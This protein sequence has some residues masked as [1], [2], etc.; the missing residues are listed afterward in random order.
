MRELPSGTVTFLFTD[1]EGS[2][3]LLH[4]LG[5]SGY[6]ESLDSHRRALRDA[7]AAHGGVEVDTQGDAFFVAFPDAEEALQA[8]REAQ[9]AL[10]A[11]S[12][13][14]RIGLHTGEPLLTDEGYVG[15]D[16]HKAARICSAGHGGQILVSERTKLVVEDG[17]LRPLGTHRLKDL[18]APEPLYQVGEAQFPPLKSLN[19]SNLPVQP[20][21]FVGREKELGEVL[22]LLRL[23]NGRV[24]TLTGPGGSGKTRLAVQA[25]AEVVEEQEHGVWWVGLQAVQDA[26]LVLP[27]IGSTV[28]AKGDL[29]EHIGNRR[30]LLVLDNLEQVVEVAPALGALLSS[31]PKLTLLVT[32]REPLHLAAEQEYPVPPFVE[33]EAV[34]FFFSRA[35][36]VRPEFEDD[37]SVRTI[38]RRLDYLPLALE[39]AAARVKA[40]SP[41]QILE[42]LEQRLPLLTGGSRDAPERQRTLRATIEWSH[43]LLSVEEQ[44]RF[45]RLSV[46]AGGC[47]LA[48]AED[49]AGA[50]VDSLQALVDKSLLRFDEERYTM[51]ETIR[52]YA[53]ERL[54]E[55]GEAGDVQRSHAAFFLALAESANMSAEGDYGRRYDILPPDQDNLRAAIDWLAAAG[56]VELA[57]RFAIA[58]ENFWVI[59]DPFEGMRR[60][61]ALLAEGGAPD[62]VRA[63]ALRCYAGSSFLAGK[64][65]QAQRANEE[66]LA[67]FREAN[68][69]RGIAE[70]LHRIGI[71]TLILGERERAQELLE[72]SL[73]LFRRLGSVRGEAEAI[74]ALGYVA[75]DAREFERALELFG[76]SEEMS[77][78]IGFTWW[79]QSMVAYGAD[80][81]FELGRIDASEQKGRR[82]LGL[83]RQVGDR[84]AMVYSLADLARNA[85]V[86]EDV[87]RAGRL[88]GALEA[89]A[90]RAPVGQWEA[91]REK[92]A[93]RVLASGGP[94]LESAREEGRRLSF[95]AAISEALENADA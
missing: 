10:A 47:T 19:Q 18:T 44:Q 76:R 30:M 68:D 41:A 46:F 42:R 27:A 73:A 9:Q 80:C 50:G 93:E 72:E 78:E 74:G 49:V 53:R 62:M 26:E 15:V 82:A 59:V 4:E 29:A 28:G 34:G 55:S 51:L 6:A 91:E 21:P 52:E 38:C 33:E 88:W 64:F 20:T 5:A 39:L 12:V 40:L 16:V 77:A 90:E 35:R 57:L 7:F 11:G 94:E 67:L 75:H 86:R 48:A 22:G 69:E 8:A 89:E 31:C 66:S 54:E 37:G 23:G 92:Y 95:E 13:R 70:L 84:Q 24:L 65:E 87:G 79:E 81:E 17:E 83:A 3:A 45:R 85:S 43:D 2:T 63:R 25:A 61:E 1:I 71:N 60:F 32:S 58:L 36:A 14:V 56:E